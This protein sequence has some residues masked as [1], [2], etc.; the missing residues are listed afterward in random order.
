MVGMADGY[1]QAT[2]RPDAGNLHTRRGSA[3][4]SATSPTP[5]HRTPM[6][7]TAGQS[8][9]P[10][11]DRRPAAVR[12][13]HR[14]GAR[15]VKWAPRDAQVRELGTMMRR[16]FQDA[17]TRP[18]GRCSCRC[19]WTS[20]TTEAGDA[21]P[22]VRRSPETPSPVASEELR[23]PP[24]RRTDPSGWRWSPP[25]RSRTR[26]RW[27]SWWPSPRRWAC[28]CTACRSRSHRLP[29]Q[30]PAVEGRRWGLTAGGSADAR[31]VSSGCWSWAD[32]AFTVYPYTPGPVVPP[33]VELLQ[34]SPDAAQLGGACPVRL[35]L[36]G[37][38][39]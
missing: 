9:P 19:R 6:V 38:A 13:A 8:R 27:P 24:D 3:T 5:G 26:A 2:R 7:V 16:A 11:H 36:A 34:I 28:R 17:A 12:C 14:V 31:R 23:R 15:T 1:V 30:P 32:Q 37:T 18:P 10:A 29:D 4:R 25:T 33:E 20:S 35:G 22:R 39:C 21:A